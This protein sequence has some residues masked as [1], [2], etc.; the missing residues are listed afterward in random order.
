[1]RVVIVDDHVLFRAAIR[2]LLEAAGVE[3][4][5]EAA[6]GD[7]VMALVQRCTPDMVLMDLG[8]RGDDGL[9]VTKRIR[10]ESPGLPV[11][12]LT[13]ST[14]RD[15][16]MRAF[17][18]GARGYL[19][20]TVDAEQFLAALAAAEQGEF[21]ILPEMARLA[22][23]EI[24]VLKP[25]SGVSASEPLTD[26]EL[27]V[28]TSMARGCTTTCELSEALRISEN[29]VKFHVRN[30]LV[31]LDAGTRAQ[32]VALALRNGIVSP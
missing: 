5:G 9:V 30:I 26:R 7:E 16:L 17:Q 20:K 21:A 29:T 27:E 25:S 32:A 22:L 19:P 14:N 23:H 12:I 31:K 2:R 24:A 18:V 10:E 13:G 1:M 3:I 8:L 4:V 11:V 6:T 28:L 15:D